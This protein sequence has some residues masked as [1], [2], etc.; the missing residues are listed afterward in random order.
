MATSIELGRQIETERQEM[1]KFWNDN[2]TADGVSTLTAEQ[3]GEFNKRNEAL[4]EKQKTFE[5]LVTAERNAA[6][7]DALLASKGR[8]IVP[9]TKADTRPQMKDA[10]DLDYAMK[11]AL[12]PHKDALKALSEGDLSKGFPRIELPFGVK[13]IVALSDHYA[14]A[15][16]LQ[17]TG[18][19]LY[20][21]SVEDLF[22]TAQTNANNVEYFI[23]TT[24]TDNTAFVAEDTAVTD[25]AFSWTKTTDEVENVQTWIPISRNMVYDEPFMVSTIQGMLADRLSKKISQQLMYGTGTTPQL[26]GCTVRSGFQTQAKGA[27]PAFDALLKAAT[28]VAVTGDATPDAFV[29]H[30]TDWQNLILTRT[31]DGLYIL[32][33]PGNPTANPTLWGLPVR[34]SSTVAAAAGTAAVGAFKTMA[35]AVYNGGLVVET[36]TEHSTYFTENKVALS[37]R[38]RMS[39]VHYR[40]SAFCKVT[41]L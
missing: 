8:V 10:G 24:D 22:G 2:K 20:Y 33:N 23:Q 13:T 36:A 26:W 15:T 27:D 40:P 35:A 21:N 1:A 25:S 14:Q 38:Q 18:S 9:D 17:T 16:R 41:G 32:G 37:L 39:A 34:V 12:A 31:T 29:I 19:A 4:G 7:N 5:A 11:S 3:I 6:Q 30:P 28:L